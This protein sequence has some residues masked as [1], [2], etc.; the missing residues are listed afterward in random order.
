GA[1]AQAASGGLL[2]AAGSSQA[3]I[4]ALMVLPG[5]AAAGT[6]AFNAFAAGVAWA[7]RGAER[8]VAAACSSMQSRV[9]GLYLQIPTIRVAALPHFRMEGDFNAETKSVPSVHVDYYAR[10]GFTRGPIAIA[11]E[12]RPE[13]V[14]S[15]DPRYRDDNIGYWL[16][17]GQMLGV[18]QPFAA[19]GI[20]Y[21]AASPLSV[22]IASPNGS[23]ATAAGSTQS[24]GG[25]TVDFGGVT[26]APQISVSGAESGDV[27]A[28]LRAARDEFMD[29]LEEWVAERMP[30]YGYVF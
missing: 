24:S 10:G 26:F 20:A 1:A 11:G 27:M 8:D 28:Q 9:S 29:E 3:M 14:I 19:G 7:M 16:M 13:A 18:M 4:A 22:D 21:G 5:T 17:A 23:L 12:E 2:I 25:V 30:D 6:A 15:F